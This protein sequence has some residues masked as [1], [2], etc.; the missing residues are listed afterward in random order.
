MQTKQFG[1]RFVYSG[2]IIFLYLMIIATFD[3]NDFNLGAFITVLGLYAASLIIGGISIM[4]FSSN[5][6]VDDL[7]SAYYAI[8]VVMAILGYILSSSGYILIIGY[9]LVG[10]TVLP[11][12]N[13]LQ[14]N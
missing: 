10:I 14:T 5:D 2:V 6:D 11:V 1:S 13:Y 4:L 3:V 12:I 8:P 7:S 9:L